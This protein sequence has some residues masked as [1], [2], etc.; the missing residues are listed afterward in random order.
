MPEKTAL[1]LTKHAKALIGSPYM[2]GTYGKLVTQDL[3]DRKKAQYPTHYSAQY[4]ETLKHFIGKSRAVDCVGLIKSYMMMDTPETT[5]VYNAQ[6]DK[7]VSGLKAACDPVGRI[8][9]L[10]NEAGVL[11]F[12]GSQHAG[13]SLGDGRAIEAKGGSTVLISKIEGRG[14]DCWGKLTWIRYGT[15]KSESHTETKSGTKEAGTKE[16]LFV[17]EQSFKNNTGKVLTVYADTSMKVPVG[18][19]PSG[20]SCNS[21]GIVLGKTLLKYRITGT[22]EYKVGFVQAS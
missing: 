21:L 7:N 3:I 15:V 22:Q 17:A 6:Y 11:L 19:I 2:W 20:N 5:P 10:P 8:D 13:I 1:G 9:T 18:S 12:M 4:C 14:W 16:G